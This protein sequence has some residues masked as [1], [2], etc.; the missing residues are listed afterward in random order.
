MVGHMGGGFFVSIVK[1]DQVEAYCQRVMQ[2]WEHHLPALYENAGVGQAYK[3]TLAGT[4]TNKIP[5]L[6]LLVCVSARSRK[7]SLNAKELFDIL[8]KIRT[9]ALAKQ[10]NGIYLD[11]RG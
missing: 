7:E 6:K 9:N 4:A 10:A 11:R 5:I 8:M 1:P 3:D 2:V